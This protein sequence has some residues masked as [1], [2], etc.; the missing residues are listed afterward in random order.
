MSLKTRFTPLAGP[1][2]YKYTPTLFTGTGYGTTEWS[3]QTG[4]QYKGYALLTATEFGCR[5][6]GKAS[7]QNTVVF[8]LNNP[9]QSY[10]GNLVINMRFATAGNSYTNWF[11]LSATYTDGT[12]ELL[13]SVS[14]VAYRNT[15]ASYQ[16][17]TK[18]AIKSLT[19]VSYVVNTGSNNYEGYQYVAAYYTKREI[20]R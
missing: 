10:D 17:N 4:E 1:I 8:T 2:P 13:V 9:V 14:G 6:G 16:F 7:N 5:H 15:S 18:K 19:L 3:T 12:S 11:T 20:D